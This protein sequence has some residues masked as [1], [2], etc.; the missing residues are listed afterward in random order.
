MASHP[1]ES[2]FH[3]PLESVD[4]APPAVNARQGAGAV[5]WRAI[6]AGAVAAAALSLVLLLLGTGLGLASVSPWSGAGVRAGTFGVAAILWVTLT[7]LAASG[8]GGYLAGRLR[9]RSSATADEVY[10]RDTAHGFL[11]W[12]LATL[13]TAAFLGSAIGGIVGATA[14]AGAS[15]AGAATAAAAV[16]A[17]GVAG[18]ASGNAPLSPSSGTAPAGGAGM[19]DPGRYFVDTLFRKDPAAPATES[20]GSGADPDARAPAAEVLRIFMSNLAS[21]GLPAE[22]QKYVAGLVAQRTGLAPADAE[23]RVTEAYARLQAR[24]KMAEQDAR[25]AADK[26]R[27]ASAY[28]SLW[29]FISLLIGAFVASWAAALGGSQRDR[30]PEHGR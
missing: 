17:A 23:K 18:V 21:G 27:K 10:F 14:Q 30:V 16:T 5:S 4:P 9:M 29:L 15:T 13:A 24:V 7:Q 8:L 3:H 11:A 6:I 19:A 28:S 20:S 1:S 25:E 2:F 22:D 12:S 26:A